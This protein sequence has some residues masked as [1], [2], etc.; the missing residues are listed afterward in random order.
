MGNYLAIFPFGYIRQRTVIA[1]DVQWVVLVR[2]IPDLT[3]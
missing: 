3:E 1:A 2:N